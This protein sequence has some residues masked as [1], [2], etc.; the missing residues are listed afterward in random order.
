MSRKHK[1]DLF[2][3]NVSMGDMYKYG[4]YKDKIARQK[5]YD[6]LKAY[7]EK[8]RGEIIDGYEYSFR[9]RWGSLSIFKY[10]PYYESK[11]LLPDGQVNKKGRKVDWVATKKL[12][13]SHPETKGKIFKYYENQH[14]DS[15]KYGVW[16]NKQ[17]TKG[18]EIQVM[19]FKA[20][21]DFNTEYGKAVLAGKDYFLRFPEY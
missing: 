20:C 7:Y 10:V 18:K 3:C 19:A 15:Y 11:P 1:T 16:W 4:K 5:Y 9:G 14:S 2:K 8:V 17:N 21:R 6:F 12:R 13:I